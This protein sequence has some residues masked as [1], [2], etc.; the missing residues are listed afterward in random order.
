MAKKLREYERKRDFSATPE[1]E[2]RDLRP[3]TRDLPRFVI[4]EHSATRLHWDLRLERDGVL[5]SWAVPN[6]IPQ[7]PKENRLAV[8]TEDHPI[9]YLDFHGEIPRGEYGAGTMTIWDTGTYEA[10]KFRSDEVILTFQGNRV[11]GR[12][13][14][15]STG[16]DDKD[17]MIH[18]MD[19]PA[20]PD[21][22]PMPDHIPPML[23]RGGQMPDDEERWGFEV[24]WDGM[25]ALVYSQPGRMRIEGR[26]AQDITARWPELR[27]MDRALH[28]HEAIL[29]GEIVAFDENGR[30]SFTRLQ[31]RM[32]VNGDAQVKRMA[33][34]VPATFVAF[35][36]LW[37]DG[38]SLLAEPYEARRERLEELELSD[39]SWRTGPS[40]R[41][42]GRPLFEAT[43]DQGL[44]GVV[45]K[46]LDS[47]YEPGHRSPSW[48]KVKHKQQ[49]RFVVA[50]W[51]PGERAIGAVLL[52]RRDDDGK[53]RYAG[54]AGSGLSEAAIESL[55]GRLEPLR[56]KTSP[57]EGTPK[58]PRGAVFAEPALTAE[59]EFSDWTDD[60][61]IRHPVWKGLCEDDLPFSARPLPKGT[62]EAEVEGRSLRISNFDKVLY[63]S[64]GF[65][66]GDV[67]RYYAR[68]APALLPHLHNRPLTLKRYPN[69]VDEKYFY[70][71]NCPSHRPDWVQTA[72][73]YSRHN[74]RDIEFCLVNDLPTLVWTANLASIELHTS[75]STGADIE[76]PTMMV[77][78]LDP[79][80]PADIVQ[81]CQ[82]AL[83]L[84]DVFDPLGLE[85]F[86]KTSGS[87][88]LQVYAP[89]NT[90]VTYADTKPFAKA[91]AELL[92]KQ[93]PELVVSRMSKDLRPG[94]VLVDW[95][96][97]DEHK[98]T[99]N[100]Y[101]L[102]AKEHP[103]VSTPVSWE[104]VEH[105]LEEG[106]SGLLFF[107]QHDVLD[108]VE[109]EGD[110][111]APV[112]A[113]TQEL[114][115]F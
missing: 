21:R 103:T 60:G 57:F 29:D 105:C 110:L 62:L 14:L 27:R 102:R 26:N 18:R 98:T 90:E 25:R 67:I 9:E 8:R 96:Q 88:G 16:R 84:R 22:E 82:V 92:E 20:D 87:K 19:P 101:S 50:G 30:P 74:K 42:E 38:H 61:V 97:N 34:A 52:G 4:H 80:A 6:G 91:V 113:L 37:L 44:E 76:R 112:L 35:D 15:F 13:A 33:K 23:A 56:R 86:P 70:E 46:R 104:E 5:M 47:R 2:P 106:D 69:G 107:E 115:R 99:V 81:C 53:L 58:P 72:S 59:V 100:V 3:A 54:R 85:L 31:R 109:R 36:L 48:I 40:Y 71:K 79:G 7:D 32:H 49:E 43:R 65:S 66:K 77:F 45:A 55:T 64:T 75:L 68:I 63:P 24:K 111:F 94:K 12:Y 78:D 51:L 11:Q 39:T 10:E 17:W 1:P 73:V 89:L 41:G 108:R 93:H 95:S 114:P 83:W 28:G